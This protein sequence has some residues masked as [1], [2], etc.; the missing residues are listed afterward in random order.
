MHSSFT[1][2][3]HTQLKTDTKTTSFQDFQ[4]GPDLVPWHYADVSGFIAALDVH[5]T[6]VR[7]LRDRY[8][9]LW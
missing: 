4:R 2:Y 8:E 9:D 6:F 5:V 1:R 7:K 3:T